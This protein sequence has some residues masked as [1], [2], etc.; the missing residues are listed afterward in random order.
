MSKPARNFVSLKD[1]SFCSRFEMGGSSRV[2]DTIVAISTPL[3]EGGIGIV[4]ISG[5]KAFSIAEKIFLSPRGK[6]PSEFESHKLYYGYIIDKQGEI[7]DEVLLVKMSARF[8]YTREDVVEINCH[9]GF[10]VLRRIVERV[11]ENGARLAEPGEFT[12][13]AFLNGRL[14]L[15]QAEA[16]LGVI[17]AKTEASLRAAIEQL[18][19]HLSRK[20]KEICRRL[21]EVRV[22]IEAGIDFAEEDISPMEDKR[23][24]E[25]IEQVEKEI[26][27]LLEGAEEGILLRRGV[28][29][30]ICGK[31]NV[32]KSSIFNL[33][34]KK[35]RAIVSPFPGTTR[36][37]I[38]ETIELKG[39]PFTLIDTAGIRESEERVEREG[40]LRTQDSLRKADLVL[41][42]VDGSV[43]IDR[44][45]R[46]IGRSLKQRRVIIVINK[47]D[48][49]QKV[50]PEKISQELELNAQIVE[51]SAKK[52]VNIKA[53]EETLVHSIWHRGVG[54]SMR[55]QALI[56]SL[57]QKESLLKAKQAIEE[58]KKGLKKG[59][60]KEFLS[61]DIKEA[62]DCLGEISGETVSEDVLERI[63]SKFCIGK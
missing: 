37:T 12:K 44:E 10:A 46:E 1:F 7:I 62:I 21:T 15:S 57:R 60:G 30:A 47:I 63:F 43:E 54:D 6:K 17:Q 61:V 9:S 16:V 2:S 23:I 20:I 18:E 5:G 49:P 29:T 25:E 28:L 31:P 52:E 13:R 38:E 59:I 39:F 32:G 55:A 4:R 34:L 40:V 48:L 33:L 11:I 50:S 53:L 51:I 14:D 35:D 3:G 19:G 26:K 41:F 24:L 36:D 22:E 58:F 45:D 56:S 42:V 8:S 27:F